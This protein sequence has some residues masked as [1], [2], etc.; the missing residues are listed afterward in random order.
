MARKAVRKGD[1]E[2]GQESDSE[3]DGLIGLIAKSVGV[4]LTRKVAWK[5]ARK[6]DSEGE[7]E[8][9]R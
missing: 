5:V 7:S 8:G 3:G 1:S 2:R 9:G 6:S 4:L